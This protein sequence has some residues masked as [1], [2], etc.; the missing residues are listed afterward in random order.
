M[1]NLELTKSPSV[2]VGMLMRTPP[3]RAFEAFRDPALTTT[4]WYTK[5][6]GEMTPGANLRWEWEMYGASTDVVVDEVEANRRI[7]FH[8]SAYD[9][10]APTQV[11]FRFDPRGSEGTYVEIIE[12]GFSGDGD[13][14]VDR[15]TSST[16]GFTF[17]LS[18]MKAYLEHGLVLHIIEDAHPDQR[19]A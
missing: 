15:V 1:S 7:A 11:E 14:V 4:F 9:P 13:T 3:E 12:S 16:A 18:S 5:S 8:W 2:K 19:V 17:V 10:N 6:S